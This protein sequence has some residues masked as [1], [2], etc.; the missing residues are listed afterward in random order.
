[1]FLFIDVVDV[2]PFSKV[3][4]LKI[5]DKTFERLVYNKLPKVS[6]ITYWEFQYIIYSQ[7]AI[8]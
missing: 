2:M 7:V 3:Y 8:S 1:M 5:C 6:I 4:H